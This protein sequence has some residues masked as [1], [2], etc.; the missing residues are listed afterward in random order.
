M[1][2]ISLF[3]CYFFLFY[4]YKIFVVCQI[5]LYK[6]LVFW[7]VIILTCSNE[8]KQVLSHLCIRLGSFVITRDRSNNAAKEK[9][10]EK[11]DKECH[12]RRGNGEEVVREV[13]ARKTRKEQ[14]MYLSFI[15][16]IKRHKR[17]PFLSTCAK[18][19]TLIKKLMS[20]WRRTH[21]HLHTYTRP[22]MHV[23]THSHFAAQSVRWELFESIR[24][25]A[26]VTGVSACV[27]V[28]ST[29]VVCERVFTWRF[30][31]C[32]I[33]MQVCATLYTWM[34]CVHRCAKLFCELLRCHAGTCCLLKN[35]TEEMS[36]PWLLLLLLLFWWVGL[37]MLMCGCLFVNEVGQRKGITLLQGVYF[38]QDTRFRVVLWGS[39]HICADLFFFVTSS[40]IYLTKYLNKTLH[41]WRWLL[42]LQGDHN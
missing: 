8:Q 25:L 41:R 6:Q 11:R 19:S 30:F 1:S 27:S 28:C 10:R 14:M 4:L 26:V 36:P 16:N 39:I 20:A 37:S 23:L 22:H 21:N 18:S 12:R 2:L 15:A 38:S 35:S 29:N 31:A 3:D 17:T 9:K 40:I 13:E 5:W 7:Y 33:A 34:L 42:T 32:T 24:V